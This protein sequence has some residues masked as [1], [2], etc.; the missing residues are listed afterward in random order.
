MRQA[1]LWA[2]VLL[3]TACGSGHAPTAAVTSPTATASTTSPLPSASPA[4]ATG[5]CDASHPCL[6]LVTLRGSDN[7]VVRDI[8]DINHPKTVGTLPGPNQ[9]PRFVSATDLSD[10]DGT[11]LY[12]MPLSGSPKT[13]VA[14]AA[15]SL[16]LFAWTSDG[17]TAAYVT[18]DGL[19]VITAGRDTKFGGPLPTADGYGCE[20]QECGDSWDSRVAFSPDDAYVS[21]LVVSGPVTGFKL[22]KSD[23]ELLASPTSQGPTMS[24]WS[25]RSFYFRD[26]AG[27]EVWRDGATSRFLSGVQW[28]RP[29]ASPAGGLIV[30]EARDRSGL[31]HTYIVDTQSKKV[32]ELKAGRSEPVFLTSRYVW[33]AGERLCLPADQCAIGLTIRTGKA[34]IYD[35]QTG[36]EYD[37]II[38]GVYDVWPHAA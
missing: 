29:K 3:L 30:Y 24:V 27:V 35:L 36:T 38:T 20:S 17:K 15:I 11:S 33:Y 18:G 2:S 22:W 14:R 9:I 1:A 34:Y 5:A 12:R 32:R 7:V 21:M 13:V 4:A 10:V 6:A 16:G 28:V 8:T 31:A 25:G 37:S 23:G 26:T 19:H